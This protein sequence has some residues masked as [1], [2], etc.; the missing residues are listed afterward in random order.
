MMV[1]LRRLL[2]FAMTLLTW[3]S[4]AAGQSPGRGRGLEI[5]FIDVMGGAAT[6]I[7]TPERESILID[8]GWP[9][10]QD[11]DPKRIVHVL[12][13]LAGCDHLDHLVTTHWHMDHFGGVGGLNRLIRIDHFW[14]RGLPEDETP[15]LDFPD[16]PKPEDPLGIAYRAAS[17]GKRKALKAGDA[18][19]I[20][21]VGALVLASGGRVIDPARRFGQTASCPAIRSATPPRPTSRS[22]SPTM[23]AAWRSSSASATSS[24]STPET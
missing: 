12:K 13:D 22:T 3:G 16:G 11:R 20:K 18:L 24:S 4:G 19:P 10:L 8:S 23:P 2:L 7:V 15:G 1:Q 17:R 14:D 6:L 21:G 5:N 9:G